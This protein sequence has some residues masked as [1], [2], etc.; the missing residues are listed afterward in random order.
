MLLSALAH[1]HEKARRKKEREKRDMR[2][3][4]KIIS[5][6]NRAKNR[7]ANLSKKQAKCASL[8]KHLP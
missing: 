3:A 8:L 4:S 6:K 1:I 5:S 2:K 7:P